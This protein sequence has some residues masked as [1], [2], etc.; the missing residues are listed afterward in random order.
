RCRAPGPIRRRSSTR[1]RPR[2]ARHRP[3][4]AQGYKGEAGG[5]S[6]AWRLRF[7]AKKGWLPNMCSHIERRLALAVLISVAS[8]AAPRAQFERTI[9]TTFDGWKKLN[10][11]SYDLV[12]GYMNRNPMDV[13]VAAGKDNAIDPAPSDLSGVPTHFLPGRQRAIFTVHVPAGF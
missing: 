7:Y 10:D 11:G 2:R 12:F 5:F 9:S 4:Q 1:G 8:V 6:S 13:D 3:R